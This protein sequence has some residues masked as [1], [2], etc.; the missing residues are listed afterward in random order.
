MGRPASR[1][2][3]FSP[4]LGST[5]SRPLPARSVS[6]GTSDPDHPAAPAAAVAVVVSPL[7]VTLAAAQ[8]D[9]V[10]LVAEMQCRVPVRLVSCLR[11]PRF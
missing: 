8:A 7:S 1:N 2:G 6:N 9:A 4:L 11:G 5:K 3:K 10:V